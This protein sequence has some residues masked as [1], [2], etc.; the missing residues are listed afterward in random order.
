MSNTTEYLPEIWE[1]WNEILVKS[2]WWSWEGNKYNGICQTCSIQP[3]GPNCFSSRNIYPLT[4]QSSKYDKRPLL[5]P[6][7]AKFSTASRCSGAHPY[8]M[9]SKTYFVSAK[10]NDRHQHYNQNL[11]KRLN[12][13]LSEVFFRNIIYCPKPC[14]IIFVHKNGSYYC[15]FLF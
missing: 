3:L 14:H 1:W 8:F 7:F 15:W 5:D 12:C 13:L 4:N 9:F 2:V 10:A 11:P 6:N